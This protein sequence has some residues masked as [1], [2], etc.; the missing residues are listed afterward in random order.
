M[1]SVMEEA[2]SR[3]DEL[4][5]VRIR[6]LLTERWPDLQVSIP[7]IKRTRREMGW[8]CTKPHYCQLLRPVSFL[9]DGFQ[10]AYGL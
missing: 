6:S 5:S 10:C 7:T 1:Q 8:V 2:Y 9:F 4:T 3:N